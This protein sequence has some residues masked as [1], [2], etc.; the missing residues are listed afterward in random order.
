MWGQ[1][2]LKSVFQASR[3]EIQVRDDVA[4]LHLKRLQTRAE[5]LMLPSGGRIPFLGYLSFLLR[6][7][8]NCIRYTHI[9]E[10][11]LLYF[12]STDCKSKSHLK[13]T[14]TGISKLVVAQQTMVTIL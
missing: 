14:F 12:E 5:F 10:D 7:S 13:I 11:N 8:T 9:M 4:L 3:L 6:L 2:N 1:A